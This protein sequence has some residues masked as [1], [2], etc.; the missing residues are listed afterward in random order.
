MFRTFG[1]SEV[2][3]IIQ[4]IQWTALLTI[5]AFAGGGALG[6]VIALARVSHNKA[7]K[8][9]AIA[10]IQ[11]IQG[12][13]VLMLLFLAYYG[14]S[15]VG[16]HLNAVIATG[17]SMILY[18]AA[19]LGDIW[20]GSIQAVPK[21]QWEAS[22]TLAMTRSQQ[23][24]YI[25]I[26]QAIRLSLPATV[27]FAVQVVKTTSI[28][29]LIGFVELTRSGQLIANVTF[30]PFPVFLTV[31]VFYFII[32]YPMSLLSRWMER[33]LYARSRN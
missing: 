26:P 18:T 15:L 10:Y 17:V 30:Q 16:F 4:S 31:A 27:G 25:I 32:C 19:F 14:L 24:R 13:P 29:A 1:M 28:A 3:F 33:K 5:A 9:L 21:A 8:G 20:R 23:I 11:T 12:I 2:W 7:V 6:L 22:E